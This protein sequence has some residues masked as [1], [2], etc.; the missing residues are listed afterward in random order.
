VIG[1]VAFLKELYCVPNYYGKQKYQ[2]SAMC[3]YIAKQ[4]KMLK[5]SK[6]EKIES[7]LIE[8]LKQKQALYVPIEGQ[9]SRQKA[10][11]ITLKQNT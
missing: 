3:N 7:L 10:E 8:R 11:E 4:K 9:V 1:V 2:T 5:T 6:Y